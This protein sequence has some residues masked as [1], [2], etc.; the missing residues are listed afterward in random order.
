MTAWV[1]PAAAI[2][3]AVLVGGCFGATSHEQVLP[4]QLNAEAIVTSHP[5]PDLLIEIDYAP[6]FAPTPSVLEDLVRTLERVTD[7]RT[8]TLLPPE[9]LPQ[10]DARFRGDV[11][12][13]GRVRGLHEEFFDSGAPDARGEGEAAFLHILYLNG[14]LENSQGD[15]V[16]GLATE[17]AAFL[18]MDEIRDASDSTRN[19]SVRLPYPASHRIERIVLL[20]EVGHLM[21]LV[22]RGAPM[23]RPHDDGTGHSTNPESVMAGYSS[24]R[25]ALLDEYAGT[26]TLPP[27]YDEDDLA[28]L[29]AL[30]RGV[31]ERLARR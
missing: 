29:A 4:A 19:A 18:F 22:N 25:G 5:Y 16:A 28:D 24:A 17:D 23:V 13:Q 31:D 7:K 3:L 27:G 14:H 11:N 12:W 10:D 8:V 15:W 2:L 20:H 21:G 6:G 1:R 30:I 9:E 26:R